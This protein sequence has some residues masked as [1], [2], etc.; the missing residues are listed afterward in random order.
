MTATSKARSIRAWLHRSLIVTICAGMV[1][2]PFSANADERYEH[3]GYDSHGHHENERHEHEFHGPWHFEP[4]HGWRFEHRPGV[5]SPLYVWWW[6]GGRAV[7]GLPPGETVVPYS[8]GY[9]E[10]RGDGISTPYYWVWIPTVPASPPQPPPAIAPEPSPIQPPPPPQP[11]GEAVPGPPA[12]GKEVGGTIIGGAVGG[13]IGSTV[14]RGS[15]RVA[16]VIVGTLLG[17]L[18]GHTIGKSLDEADE[19]RAAYALEQNKTGQ[20]STWVNPDTGARVTVTPTRTYQEPSGQYCREYQTE[21]MVDGKRHQA[22]GTACRQPGG[23][24]QIVR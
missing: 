16:G 12:G 19:L 7:L 15:G 5:W 6:L 20:E 11:E 3:R 18:V 9:Y 2:T 24:W 4:H 23:Q 14:G 10:L 1:F 22:V 21:I 8:T 13:A 17:A